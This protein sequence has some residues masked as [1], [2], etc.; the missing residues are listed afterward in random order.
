MTYIPAINFHPNNPIL[1][2]STVQSAS[3]H[4]LYTE[5]SI[6][7]TGAP[8]ITFQGEDTITF[9]FYN[10]DF[11]DDSPL[12]IDWVVNGS[13]LDTLDIP[14]V[15]TVF[16]ASMGFGEL[17]FS[18]LTLELD[19][20]TIRCRARFEQRF[21]MM[22]TESLLLVQGIILDWEIFGLDPR[23]RPLSHHLFPPIQ[24]LTHP[25]SD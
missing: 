7:P 18:N 19:M 21:S 16:S 1:F 24:F 4:S 17:R 15:V 3:L 10:S 8:H 6:F 20:T 5:V 14:N 13:F 22:S 23:A 25:I 2:I 9:C 11:Y 12:G